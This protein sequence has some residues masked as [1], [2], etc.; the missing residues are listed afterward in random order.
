MKTTTTRLLLIFGII[1]PA[2]FW[3]TT[4]ICGA[5]HGNYDHLSGT[6]SELGALGTRSQHLFTG[7]L[8]LLSVFGFG[9]CLGLYRICCERKLS[10]LPLIPIIIFFLGNIGVAL[11]PLGHR[12]HPVAGEITIIIV[13]SPMLALWYWRTIVPRY[14]SLLATAI[15]IIAMALVLLEILSGNFVQSHAGLLQRIFHAGWTCWF[16]SLSIQFNKTTS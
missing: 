13:L 1:C 4:L 8:I 2:L 14:L 9:F 12:L 15:I 11:F 6:I 3:L 16:I 5:V 10:L 7:L